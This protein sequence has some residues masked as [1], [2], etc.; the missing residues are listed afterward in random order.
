VVVGKSYVVC[1]DATDDDILPHATTPLTYSLTGTKN[2]TPFDIPIGTSN[3]YSGPLLAEVGTYEISV[4]VFDGC[5]PTI[6]GPVEVIVEC[7]GTPDITS[8]PVLTVCLGE[9]YTYQVTATDPETDPL[10][11]SLT[12]KP[13]GMSI[14]STGLITWTPASTGT[15]PVAVE[16]SD[17]C[18]SDTQE[19]TVTVDAGLTGATFAELPLM[20][21]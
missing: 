21:D 3:C 12:T 9:E 1:V 5:E 17:G 14:N 15:Y 6:W 7:N 20:P 8:E 11:Y 19:F 18:S 10:I 16:V 2:G 4:K 13:D